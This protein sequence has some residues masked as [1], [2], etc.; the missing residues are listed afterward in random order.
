MA[1]STEEIR[2]Q[3]RVE[4]SEVEK[5]LLYLNDL[6][7]LSG[8]VAEEDTAE[9][10]PTA[11]VKPKKT[12]ASKKPKPELET[13]PVAIEVEEHSLKVAEVETAEPE[14]Y[15]A[16]PEQEKKTLLNVKELVKKWMDAQS[17]EIKGDK[18]KARAAISE[19]FKE[20][21]G[22]PGLKGHVTDENATVVFYKFQAHS[23]WGDDF[24]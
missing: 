17:A 24:C 11:Q 18:K 23:S 1:R 12:R 4:I 15:E 9:L 8:G 19:A 5:R 14:V 2:A 7:Y 21:T 3:L 16:E 22:L 10:T 13:E 6:L 20:A